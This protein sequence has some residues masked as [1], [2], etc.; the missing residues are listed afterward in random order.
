MAKIGDRVRFLNSVGGGIIKKI[1]GNIAY[2]DDDGF[3]T[4]TLLRECVVVAEAATTEKKI[5]LTQD[6]VK[7]A[8]PQPQ[9]QKPAQKP[10]ETPSVEETPE[11][12]KLNVVLAY[13]PADIKHLN[14]TTFDV[15]LVNDSNYYLYFTY[16]TR[17]DEAAGWTTRYAGIVEPNIQV[18][19]EEITGA[20]LPSM[21][22]IAVQ[23]IAFKSDKEFKMKAPVAVE[24]ALDT[25]KFFKLHCFRSNVYFDKDVIAVDI[26]TNDIPRKRMVI[27]SSR[28]EE[29]IKAKKAVD[30][31]A[32][33]PVQKKSSDKR[34]EIIEVDLHISE[35]VDTTAGLSAADILNLQIDE[36]RKVMDANLKHKGQ[37]IV[38][39]H[40]KG[41]GVLRAALMKELNH[42][43][44]GHTVQDASFR[45]YGFGATQVTI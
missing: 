10:A 32:R 20:D 18:F 40:G 26:V 38:F 41:E 34:A 4:P 25:T 43:Y 22:R 19:L 16:L 14:S 36:F 2:V 30:R 1:E 23:M 39:I 13:E 24:T 15:Y 31:P 5:A 27:D 35:L 17:A 37:K 12:E 45:E 44:K 9:Q 6:A 42:R 8:A 3:E 33:K 11:G 21:D 29:G 28:I 7:P